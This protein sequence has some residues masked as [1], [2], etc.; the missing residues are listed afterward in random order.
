M[1]ILAFD[2]G[3]SGGKLMEGQFDGKRIN[4]SELARFEHSAVRMGAGLYWGLAGIY[5]YLLEALRKAK[6][7]IFSLGIDSFSNDF[8]F[9]DKNGELLTPIRCYRDERTSRCADYVYR[10]LSPRALYELTGNQNA[11]F[12]TLMQLGAM[13]AAGQGWVLEN[14]H[15][16]LFVP[17]L[18]VYFLTGQITAEYTVSS[19]SQ[20]YSYTDNDFS[21]EILEAFNIRRDLFGSLVMPGTAA[22]RLLESLC[23]DQGISPFK[24]VSVCG[25]DTASAYLSS[26]LDRRDAVIISSGTWSLMGCELEAPLINEA[27]YKHNIANE[28]G[29]PGHHRFLKN[30]MGSWIIQEIRAG[31][32]AKGVE[33]SYSELEAEAKKAVP[34]AHFI[35]V[36]DDLFFSPG[37]P[38]EKIQ[39][40]CRVKYGNAPEETG[41]LIRCVY[42]SLAM[43]YRRNLEILKN[44]GG[45]SFGVI[46]IIGGGSKDSLICQF[47]ADACKLPVVAGPQEA[48]ILGNI[49]VQLI[50]AGEI[51]SIKEGREIIASSFP[52]VW[53]EPENTAQWDEAYERF[54]ALFPEVPFLRF[55]Q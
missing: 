26:P 44:V 50:S 43:K 37:N 49:L 45:M 2:L 6:G 40:A 33:Y 38:V 5:R 1:N 32:R 46:N 23:R 9:I 14:A 55:P 13:Q 12:N 10:R 35:D 20:L 54:C 30:V 36:D 15:K 42:D 41:E 16:L 47:T 19:V 28:G 53:Y 11:Q 27:A 34:F 25:H 51:A 29:Y 21:R 39:N 18:F 31:F 7:P 8:G 17:D 3:G 22:G 52:P 4:L 24:V 48:A